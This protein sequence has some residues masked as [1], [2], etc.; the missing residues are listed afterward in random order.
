MNASYTIS[1]MYLHVLLILI[2]MN[3]TL[4][5]EKSLTIKDECRS[6]NGLPCDSARLGSETRKARE[7]IQVITWWL[8]HP[9]VQLS[10]MQYIGVRSGRHHRDQTQPHPRRYVSE[11]ARIRCVNHNGNQTVEFRKFFH[12][13]RRC[14]KRPSHRY[15]DADPRI[16]SLFSS[17]HAD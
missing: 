1:V 14:S 15:R 8:W 9:Q 17:S 3:Q 16:E 6:I 7:G 13:M 4:L 10:C 2:I 5:L 12:S 11:V